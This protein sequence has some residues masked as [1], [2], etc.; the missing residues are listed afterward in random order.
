MDGWKEGGGREGDG[1]GGDA[2]LG[3]G[4]HRSAAGAGCQLGPRARR[5]QGDFLYLQR[6]LLSRDPESKQ[7]ARPRAPSPPLLLLDRIYRWSPLDKNQE[8]G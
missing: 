1:G 8:Q 6:C 5:R 2:A 3:R 7:P 4:C